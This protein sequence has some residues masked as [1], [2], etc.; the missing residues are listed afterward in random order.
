VAHE[1]HQAMQ[2]QLRQVTH[3]LEGVLRNQR[4]LVDHAGY[5]LR[6]SRRP[7]PGPPRSPI[8]RRRTRPHDLAGAS[9]WTGDVLSQIWRDRLV[10]AAAGA[11]LTIAGLWFVLV[12]GATAAYVFRG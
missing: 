9:V 11:I 5:Q 2:Q 12:A 10:G 8:H 3:V 4:F 6:Q 1:R 7:A